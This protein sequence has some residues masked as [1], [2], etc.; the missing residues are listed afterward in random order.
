MVVAALDVNRIPELRSLLATM[1]SA[2]GTA[3][4]NNAI[5]PFGKFETLHFARIVVLEDQT[6]DDITTAYGIARRS[7]PT[8]LAFLA[9][10]DGDAD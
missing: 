4:P 9:D 1:N 3:D 8:Y 7:Y 2:P 5:I 10:F 6:L